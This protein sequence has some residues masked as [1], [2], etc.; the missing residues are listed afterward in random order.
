MRKDNFLPIIP[1]AGFTAKTKVIARQLISPILISQAFDP[2]QNVANH[3]PKKEFQAIWDT[4]AT[5]TV[6]TERVVNECGLK[7]IGMIRVETASGTED[8]ETYIVNAE[9][10]NRVGFSY[11]KVS[12]GKI[13]GIDVLIGMDIIS[14]GDLAISN[15]EGKTTFAF[16]IPSVECIDF[17][18]QAKT[19]QTAALQQKVRRNDP[20]PCGSGKKFKRCHGK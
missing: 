1:V 5:N 20:C 9:L 2:S 11:L 14:H 17:N 16:R 18:P 8:T 3:P 6:I 19:T 13:K 10:P 4:G 12:K 15:F 7:P